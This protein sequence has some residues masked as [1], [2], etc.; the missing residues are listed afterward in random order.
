MSGSGGKRSCVTVASMPIANNHD[1]L[2]PLCFQALVDAAGLILRRRAK[3]QSI[4]RL[5]HIRFIPGL[6]PPMRHVAEIHGGPDGFGVRL[7]IAAGGQQQG[8]SKRN[9]S[10][11]VE[12]GH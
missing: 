1:R 2:E 8:R 10:I 4:I 5:P 12:R 9:P 3:V 11:M 6:N 7:P